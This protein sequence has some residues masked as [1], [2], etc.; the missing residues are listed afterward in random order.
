MVKKHS[1][2]S[3]GL[4]SL[5][6]IL[7]LGTATLTA[8]LSPE[9]Q[10]FLEQPVSSLPVPAPNTRDHIVASVVVERLSRFHYTP[11][12][13]TPALSSRW[14]DEYFKL[15]DYNKMYFLQSDLDE[16]RIRENQLWNKKQR[17]ANLK[18]A[19]EIYQRYLERFHDW[20][21]FSVDCAYE[22]HDFSV[23][24]F[25]ELD[26]KNRTWET[27]LDNLHDYWRRRVKSA[28]LGNLLAA[29]EKAK[30]DQEAPDAEKENVAADPLDRDKLAENIVRSYK[31]RCEFESVEILEIFLNAYCGLYDP[32]SDY[33]GPDTKESFDIEMKLSLEGIGAVLSVKDAYITIES[34]MAGSPAEKSGRL[35]PGDRITAVAQDGEDPVD[36]IDM[37]LSKAVKMIRGPKGSKVHLTILPDGASTEQH[38]TLVRDLIPMEDQAAQ[39]EL[40]TIQ[41]GDEERRILVIYLPSFYLDFK[42]RDNGK[43]DFKSSSRDITAI[44][45]KYQAEE[46]F[47]GIILDLRGNG[48][49]SLDEAVAV[50]GLFLPDS[51]VVKVRNL[52]GREAILA[53]QD[54]A[55]VYGGPLT[56]L[57]DRLSASASEIVAAC[58]QD[59]GRAII[60][61]EKS[62]HGKGTVQTLL[63][64]DDDTYIQKMSSHLHGEP[65]GCLKFTMS[66]FY[67]VNGGSTQEKGVIPDLIFPSFTDQME[68]GESNLPNCLP[69][70]E[71]SP[72][73]MKTTY[74]G[75]NCLPAFRQN[76]QEYLDSSRLYAEYLE[77]LEFAAAVRA[78]QQLPLEIEARRQYQQDEE[79]ATDMFL[80]FQAQRQNSR[81][82]PDNRQETAPQENHDIILDA[83]LEA[84]ARTL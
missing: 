1:T 22:D 83:V 64:L 49:G 50:A 30:E 35:R 58:L 75:R 46:N 17:A 8:G 51:P 70:D 56:V 42:E 34:I 38:V 36:V 23:Q 37:K 40:R 77:D 53:D 13:I 63:E 66:K 48:G 84:M 31:R 78:N 33:M 12:E 59:T 55:V 57:T 76:L 27:S 44:I 10:E 80:K 32:H 60:A 28:L 47:D 25:L 2:F 11:K 61:G 24:E 45:R 6:F 82:R 29:E 41:V 3:T 20:A 14:F 72:I 21:V 81:R 7:I 43:D 9:L 39:G 62:T 73:P 19:F 54:K 52:T 26:T 4:L 69:W 18:L 15:L 71:I 74:Q 16:F 68:L 67:R 79:K 5:L 65:T